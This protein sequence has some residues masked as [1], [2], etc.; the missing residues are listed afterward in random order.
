MTCPGPSRHE[1]DPAGAR[2]TWR[3]TL[4]IVAIAVGWAMVGS[5]VSLVEGSEPILTA[6]ALAVFAFAGALVVCLS[7]AS[8]SRRLSLDSRMHGVVG[9]IM[10]SAYAVSALARGSNDTFTTDPWGPL[11]IGVVMVAIAP[12]RPPREIVFHGGTTAIFVGFITYLHAESKESATPPQVLALVA[13][14]GVLGLC[15]GSAMFSRRTIEALLRW[16][17]RA[18][19]ASEAIADELRATIA[20]SVY[21]DRVTILNRDVVPFFTEV[22]GRSELTDEDRVR[23][24]SISSAIRGIMVADADRSWLTAVVER[25]ARRGRSPNI[26]DDPQL[27]AASMDLRA[28]TA[29]RALIGALV[30]D[31]NVTEGFSIA[32]ARDDDGCVGVLSARIRESEHAVRT[33]YAPFFAV[34]KIAFAEFSEDFH[35]YDQIVRFTYERP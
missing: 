3:L 10:V 18:D 14:I 34:M 2:G 33:H 23:A 13:M 17:K 35:H 6:V 4:T 9:A 12:Y 20:Q 22:L 8:S 7:G 11:S 26:V 21:Q 5:A 32:L 27:L 15:F 16:Q 1:L 31:P 25:D 19:V 30:D 28:R 29:L 24:K